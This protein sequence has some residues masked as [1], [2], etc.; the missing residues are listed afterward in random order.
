MPSGE[1]RITRLAI[2]PVSVALASAFQCILLFY[3][4]DFVFTTINPWAPLNFWMYRFLFPV[5]NMSWIVLIDKNQNHTFQSLEINQYGNVIKMGRKNISK[6]FQLKFDVVCDICSTQR[7]LL[8]TVPY[9]TV[10]SLPQF[11]YFLLNHV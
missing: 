2:D 10:A 4:T 8:P 3:R 5:I 1:R 7:I 6:Q 9:F 11:A